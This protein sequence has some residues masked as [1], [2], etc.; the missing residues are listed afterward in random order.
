[1]TIDKLSGS[2]RHGSMPQEPMSPADNPLLEQRVRR[3]ED[4]V[5]QLQ[6][7]RQLEDRVTERLALRL[8]PTR[9]ADGI[10]D[11]PPRHLPAPTAVLAHPATVYADS[12]YAAA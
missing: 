12:S 8:A 1:M 9:T 2:P 7:L 11:P 4:S 3:L 6:D 5:A 10:M